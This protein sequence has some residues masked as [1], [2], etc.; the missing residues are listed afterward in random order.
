MR[1]LN[2]PVRIFALFVLFVSVATP[3][4]ADKI[5]VR[6]GSTYGDN[7]GVAVC[8]NNI[9]NDPTNNCEGFTAGTFT[10]GAN[11]YAGALFV[12]LEP[13]TGIFG[14]LDII[15]FT[16]TNLTLSLLNPSA[17]TGVFMCGSFDKP[18]SV[19]QDSTLTNMTGLPC[20]FGASSG[21]FNASQEVPGVSVTFSATGVT[22][23]NGNSG[24]LTGFTADGNIE[25]ATFTPGGTISTA[26]P[27]SLVLLGFGAL[28][29][30]RKFRRAS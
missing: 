7:T 28:V 15:Q 25:G 24:P 17:P 6:G 4:W 13:T 19:A 22:F 8:L 3:S 26:E 20:T 16:G 29:I 18:L 23:G 27:G 14:T 9:A 1:C 21:F 10:I 2:L 12:F 5:P 11:T 30:G